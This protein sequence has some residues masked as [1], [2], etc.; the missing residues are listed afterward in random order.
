MRVSR[1]PLTSGR[2]RYGTTGR[3]PAHEN[4]RIEGITANDTVIFFCSEIHGI[5]LFEVIDLFQT[6]A[7]AQNVLL[8][9][10][11]WKIHK[12]SNLQIEKIFSG[13]AEPI[14]DLYVL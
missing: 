6:L 9:Q 12:E 13:C 11:F 2:G 5:C 14:M 3:I 7:N 1:K 8:C 4:Y 10:L